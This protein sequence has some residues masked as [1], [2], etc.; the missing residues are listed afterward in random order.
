MTDAKDS[1]WHNRNFLV[2][3]SSQTISLFGSSISGLAV[4]LIAVLLL[5]ATPAQMGMLKGAETVPFI[6]FGL[7]AGVWVDRMRRLP[8]LFVSDFC[9]ALLLFCIPLAHH[10]GL[11]HIHLL[12][13][14]IF[15]SS[16]FNVFY[17]VAY[18]SFLPS[19]VARSQLVD[20]NS[21]LSL[22]VSVAQTAGPALGGLLIELMGAP[23][24]ITLDALSFLA[25][26]SLLFTIKTREEPV[27]AG[28]MQG[29]LVSEI[30]TGLAFIWHDALFRALTLR[31]TAWQL[32]VG[33]NEVLVILLMAQELKF[34]PGRIGVVYAF[35]GGGLFVGA[36][37]ARHIS[38]RLGVGNT[39]VASV[40]FGALSAI[41]IPFAAGG[42]LMATAMLA[43][44]LFLHGFFVILYQINNASLR[45]AMTPNHLLGRMNATTR[46]LTLG[47]RPLG[48]MVGG[49]LAGVIGLRLT[50]GLSIGIGI[51]L[52]LFGVTASA[53]R[54]IVK[55][56]ETAKTT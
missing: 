49:L 28:A 56:P 35:L 36:F 50:M 34:S 6:L 15:A 44:A 26:A 24:A 22:S 19:L 10:F 20:A 3:W 51:A 29:G 40:L 32:I 41:L 18:G 31:L 25:S 16:V 45:Q 12:Y 13:A 52:A 53:L 8:I 23:N 21:K 30:K 46:F 39:I 54:R 5:H 33:L 42:D 37:F 38:L 43:L 2:L 11:L 17:M 9:R 4:P 14:V 1:I 7:V 27:A 55:L 47:V 48:A